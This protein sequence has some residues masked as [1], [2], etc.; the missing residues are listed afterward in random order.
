VKIGES[1]YKVLH[2]VDAEKLAMG[3]VNEAMDQAKEQ[4]K[5]MYKDRVAKYEPI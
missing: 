2:L 3:Y 1:L 5:D 4:I